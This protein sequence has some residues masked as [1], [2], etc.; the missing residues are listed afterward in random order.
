M[1]PVKKKQFN[2][3]IQ[4]LVSRVQNSGGL[5]RKN[6]YGPFFGFLRFSSC[7][8]AVFAPIFMKFW[9][10]PGLK[11]I[12]PDTLFYNNFIVTNRGCQAN[13]SFYEIRWLVEST[14][15][16][17]PKFHEDWCKNGHATRKKPK[18]DP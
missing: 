2:V 17:E 12:F 3:G 14:L 6:V 16:L 4:E 15:A 1:V 5:L 7:S 13:E 9:L 18:M 10:Q 8:M 11:L